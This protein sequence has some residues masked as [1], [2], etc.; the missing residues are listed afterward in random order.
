V[1]ALGSK[2]GGWAAVGVVLGGLLLALLVFAGPGLGRHLPK[3]NQ[4]AQ[5]P[6]VHYVPG[7]TAKIE[8]LVG[9]WDAQTKQPTTNRTESR[10]G[11]QGT[12]LG[13]SFEYK[14]QL[15][16]LFG[17]TIGPNG[18]DPIAYS[19][20]T[21]PNAPLL[22][23]FP[24]GGDGLYLRVQPPEIPM[25]GYAVPVGGVEV[26]GT[27]YLAVKTAVSRDWATDRT[28]LT[29]YDDGAHTFTAVRLLSKMPEGHFITQSMRLAPEGLPGLPTNEP[30]VLIFGSGEYR[31]SSAYL[32]A[33]PAATFE[34]G[35]GTVFYTGRNSK[36][37]I[38]SPKEFDAAPVI[39]HST[40]GDISVTFVPQIGLW[41][42]L[43]DSRSPHGVLLRSA[44]EPWGPWSDPQILLDPKTGSGSLIHDPE[45][46]PED[47]LAGPVIAEGHAPQQVS[48]GFYAP[49]I[50]DRFTRVE[51]DI[52]TLQY[53][54]ST[55]NPYVV[56]RMKSSFQI[57][58]GAN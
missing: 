21:D 18:G 49:Y 28:I 56:L 53:V 37:P 47:G 54:L 26:N 22:L 58:P 41:L 52:V 34:T 5:N 57:R 20:S 45:R 11:I 51:G 4:S 30:Y 1:K 19:A 8:Q 6:S 55:W 14:G 43:Y 42:A 25:G 32:A 48:G 16:L 15:I 9:D 35:A 10:F 40:I 29:R 23:E 12:D 2:N 31:K 7:S 36:G 27:M 13:S 44:T 50:I 39:D 17:D 38:W 46:K 33:V 3:T 24:R